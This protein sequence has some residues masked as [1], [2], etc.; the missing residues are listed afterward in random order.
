MSNNELKSLSVNTIRTLCRDAVQA[1]NSG[2]PGTP[3]GIAPVA[4]VFMSRW[5]VAV[6]DT[7]PAGLTDNLA[8]AVGL[9]VYWAYREVM[10]SQ[11]FQRLENADV[12]TQRLLWAST[13]TKDPAASDTL[14]VH[15]LAAPF[16]VDRMPDDTL[17]SNVFAQAQALGFGKTED[18]V[19]AEGTAQD[20]APHRVMGGN[21]PTN[22]LLAEVLTPYRLGTGSRSTST[23]CS[24]RE[25][26]GGSTPST[27]GASSWARCLPSRSSRSSRARPSLRSATTRRRTR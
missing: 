18:E 23:A 13:R 5:D 25:R 8:V 27:S 22:V 26:S 7:A 14:Y 3:M 15:G 24:P 12:R 6:K 19:R 10:G 9:D 21:R 17:K 16:T 4:S 1:A 2:R 11:R 20:V